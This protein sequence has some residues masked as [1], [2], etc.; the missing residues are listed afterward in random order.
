MQQ[1]LRE[2]E[3]V[4]IDMF[5]IKLRINEKGVFRAES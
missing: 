4:D 5:L 1:I 3:V 2:G